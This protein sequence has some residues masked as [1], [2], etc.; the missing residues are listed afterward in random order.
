MSV[1][2]AA[3]AI[4]LA[5][6]AA[7][8]HHG[9]DKTAIVPRKFDHQAHV[10]R[11]VKIGESCNECHAPDATGALVP[12][13]KL[14][15]QPCLAAGCHAG[16]FLASNKTGPTDEDRYHR[17]AAFCLGCHAS[18]DGAPPANHAR[19]RADNAFRGNADPDYHAD[20][21]HFE[22]TER[23]RCTECHVVD[24]RTYEALYK[25]GHAQCAKCH[26]QG[27]K[28]PMMGLCSGCHAEP[29]RN[30]LYGAERKALDL[31]SCD[32]VWRDDMTAEEKAAT[33][34]FRH[35]RREHRFLADGAQL[36]CDSCHFM[37]SEDASKY[38]TVKMIKE[39][40]IVTGATMDR[41]CGVKGCHPDVDST[42]A[43]KC[44]RC[45]HPNIRRKLLEGF[46]HG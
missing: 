6:G 10:A 1:R 3:A 18:P 36:Q 8:A 46:V 12:V 15:H 2:L 32:S 24:E 37:V 19:A 40:P 38:R 27:Q 4:A 22:H 31:K 20:F 25:P 5:A 44:E 23:A 30:E 17:A 41:Y 42:A 28:T 26:S 45:H 29:G 13:G 16:D 35:E 34:C 11:G 33:P 7:L 9:A 14:G 43:G 39:R 21:D